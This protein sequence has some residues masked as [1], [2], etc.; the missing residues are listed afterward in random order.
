MLAK[1]QPYRKLHIVQRRDVNAHAIRHIAEIP[2]FVGIALF[3]LVA[4]A[5]ARVPV[6]DLLLVS[7]CDELD[8][9]ASYGRCLWAETLRLV[10]VIDPEA[11]PGIRGDGTVAGVVGDV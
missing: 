1:I 5:R 9:R 7:L 10:P 3:E 2:L 4:V 11:E 6:V 8:E